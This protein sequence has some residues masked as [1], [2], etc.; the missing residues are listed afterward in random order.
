VLDPEYVRALWV[1]YVDGAFSCPDGHRRAVLV[2]EHLDLPDL[3]NSYRL[4][5][6]ECA[7]QTPAFVV[8]RGVV[9][10]SRM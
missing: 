5:C 7:F 4:Y 2:V 8:G 3:P 9:Q 1:A 10:V 6:P